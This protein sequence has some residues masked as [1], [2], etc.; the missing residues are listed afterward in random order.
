MSRSVVLFPPALLSC[1]PPLFL[2][3]LFPSFPPP[4]LP[5]LPSDMCAQMCMC[6]SLGMEAGSQTQMLFGLEL[7]G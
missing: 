4:L 1:V 5:P 6:K 7:N 3:S 2:P